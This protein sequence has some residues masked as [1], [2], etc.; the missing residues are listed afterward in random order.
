M[1]KTYRPLADGG[2]LT[3]RSAYSWSL[4]GLALGGRIDGNLAAVPGQSNASPMTFEMQ[5]PMLALP[6][7]LL[8]AVLVAIWGYRLWLG[9]RWL[10]WSRVRKGRCIRCGYL[11]AGVQDH[12]CPECGKFVPRKYRR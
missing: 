3:V 1:P 11:M 7:W 10:A 12:R 6:A 2:R 9:P 8:L 4:A 5:A